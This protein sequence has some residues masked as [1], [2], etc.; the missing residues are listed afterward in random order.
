MTK[1][2]QLAALS[3]AA[4][5]AAPSEDAIEAAC[6]EAGAPEHWDRSM[7]EWLAATQDKPLASAI[8]AL[9]RRIDRAGDLVQRQSAPVDWMDVWYEARRAAFESNSQAAADYLRDT[10]TAA[11]GQGAELRAEV[12]DP[13]LATGCA[14]D[15][16]P[17]SADQWRAALSELATMDG[18]TL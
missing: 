3:E 10:I 4:T 18:E 5:Q 11:M 14:D 2:E 15:A 17:G 7:V 13:D 8:L 6:R 16:L 1:P 9:A 12:D